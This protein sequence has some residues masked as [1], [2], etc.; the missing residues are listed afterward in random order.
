MITWS[1]YINGTEVN[2]MNTRSG[3][4]GEYKEVGRKRVKY[5]TAIV[6]IG[7]D[8]DF[9]KEVEKLKKKNTYEIRRNDDT[10]VRGEF[11]RNDMQFDDY[12][13]ICTIQTNAFDDYTLI[14]EMEEKEVNVLECTKYTIKAEL[15][16]YLVFYTP[17]VYGRYYPTGNGYNGGEYVSW[18][19]VT[20]IPD[21]F[22][23]YASNVP[24]GITYDEVDY[25]L[26]RPYLEYRDI[27]AQ[28][29]VIVDKKRELSEHE[30]KLLDESSDEFN[31]YARINRIFINE[32]A[33]YTGVISSAYTIPTILDIKKKEIVL[34]I[35]TT[36]G[37]D[38][39]SY[40]LTK[41]YAAIDLISEDIY[42]P[43]GGW[44]NELY[45][46]FKPVVDDVTV[47]GLTLRNTLFIKKTIYNQGAYCGLFTEYKN[48]VKL[49]SALNYIFQ[50]HFVSADKADSS[51]SNV[52]DDSRSNHEISQQWA[53]ITTVSHEWSS[54]GSISQ[55]LSSGGVKSTFLFNSESCPG[56][57]DYYK[58]YGSKRKS[59]SSDVPQGTYY[60]IHKSD[61]IR[62]TAAQAATKGMLSFKQARDF[63]GLLKHCD[64]HI[65]L[66][67]KVRIE[68]LKYYETLPQ[69]IKLT[70][71]SKSYSYLKDDTPARIVYEFSEGWMEDFAKKEIRHENVP[72]LNG[73]KENKLEYTLSGFS[74]DIDGLNQ[75]LDSISS[76]GWVLIEV[77]DDMNVA[78]D[79]GVRSGDKIQNGNLSLVNCLRMDYR[80]QCYREDLYI[81][82]VKLT[83]YSVKKQKTQTLLPFEIDSDINIL[84]SIETDLGV[85]EFVSLKYP[86]VRGGTYKAEVIYE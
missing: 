56:E 61:F 86:P 81:D 4:V 22:T 19:R 11:V 43:P 74:T 75:R 85:G 60:L 46:I 32:V 54:S 41:E 48:A 49:E 25:Q 69:G 37:A 52:V 73:E 71:T 36:E 5:P 33:Y 57:P 2:P 27:Y 83:A 39:P 24:T 84:N 62:P 51:R 6:L 82:D 72:V 28:E 16:S 63:I 65:D 12:K 47:T 23:L 58:D 66:A 64:W 76:E 59:Y 1:H 80:H 20:D 21:Y 17:M 53:A 35:S 7:D 40:L 70:G 44:K 50:S 13:K 78:R 26:N 29:R 8:Y 10:K 34:N 38:V 67:N 30:W 3:E 31:L 14:N 15:K 45:N 68:H 55:Q 18:G 9:A 77:D 42:D 79:K